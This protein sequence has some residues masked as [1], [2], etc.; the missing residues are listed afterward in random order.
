MNWQ[1]LGLIFP[2][3]VFILLG[4]F[5]WRG[6]SL[7]PHRIPSALINKP[8]PVFT[9][10]D[11]ENTANTFSNKDLIGHVSLVNV[12]ASWCISCRVEHPVLVDIARTS[13]VPIYGIDYKDSRV[14]ARHWLKTYGNPYTK[15]G[16]DPHGNVAINW[17]VYG[18][19]ETFVIDKHGIIRDKF[20]GP[21]TPNDWKE[22]L[23]P[24]VEKLKHEK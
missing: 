21:I 17:G 2:L 4:V 20:I 16:F 14:N 13:H 22:K 23:L 8:A 1:R 15:I 3:I 5:L 6:L 12:W 18:T 7:H 24:E 10:S 19:P 11:V 9:L